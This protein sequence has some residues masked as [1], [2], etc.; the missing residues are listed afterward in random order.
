MP[1]GSQKQKHGHKTREKGSASEIISRNQ[2]LN[3]DTLDDARISMTYSIKMKKG[4]YIP[5][6]DSG[7]L[8]CMSV[9]SQRPIP[10]K[11]LEV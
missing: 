9:F 11:F 6:P 5:G 2:G 8:L 4:Y 1:T 10:L 3:L 7:L